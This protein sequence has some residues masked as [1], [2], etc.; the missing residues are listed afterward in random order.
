MIVAGIERQLQ[1][2]FGM[3]LGVLLGPF[4]AA[5]DLWNTSGTRIYGRCERW[6]PGLVKVCLVADLLIWIAYLIIPMVL[7]SFTRRRRDLPFPWMFWMFGLFI[8]GCG[9]THFF[10]VYSIFW[11]RLWLVAGVKLF[12]AA[13]SIATIVAIFPTMKLAIQLRSPTELDALIRERTI[14]LAAV[15]ASLQSEI[16]GHQATQAALLTAQEGLELRVRQRTSEIVRANEA[17]LDEIDTRKQMETEL[18]LSEERFRSLVESVRDY[19]ILLLDPMGRVESW[20]PAAGRMFGYTAEAILGAPSAR[21]F[22]EEDV[23][24]GLPGQELAVAAAEGRFEAEGWRVRQ[25]GSRFW[26]NVVVN[27][28]RDDAGALRG[29]AKLARDFTERKR[30]EQ[31]LKDFTARLQRSNSELEEFASVA[32]HDLQEPLRKIQSFGDQLYSRYAAVLGVQG[33][34]DLGRIQ[35]AASR[36]RRLIDD[37]L[38]FARITSNAKAFRPVDLEQVAREVVADLEGRIEQTGA[39]V[40]VGNLPVI[41]A[42]PTQMRQLFQN[43]IGNGLKFHRAD[44]P[45]VV[46]VRAEPP[47]PAS[48]TPSCRIIVEDNGIGFD[49][50]HRDR[51]FKLFERLHGRSEYEG[52]GMGLAICRKIVEWHGGSITAY[53]APGQ[54]ATFV[55]SMPSQQKTEKAE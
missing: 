22:T 14:E 37:L 4:R 27:S 53:S 5:V 3:A 7:L 55:V 38:S 9:F 8:L 32:S 54:G 1:A 33:R 26:A 19:A 34:E 52:T 10:E 11:P 42:E 16:S 24:A 12:T 51:I 43:L 6:T 21:F 35:A 40:D 28:L 18:R 49:E 29:F 41:D 39:R 13:V 20:N 44:L 23:A 50:K 17:L 46:T 31:G 48:A 30:L 25:D 36:M 47:S 2:G 15:N 45:P